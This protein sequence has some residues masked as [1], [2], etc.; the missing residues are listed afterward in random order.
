[1]QVG[2]NVVAST[3]DVLSYSDGLNAVHW[4]AA[5]GTPEI[6]EKLFHACSPSKVVCV[7]SCVSNRSH[8]KE[9]ERLPLPSPFCFVYL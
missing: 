7:N 1:M 9:I 5:C 3:V 8:M 2:F 6:I 4:S